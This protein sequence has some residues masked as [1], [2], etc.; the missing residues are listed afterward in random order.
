M[1]TLLINLRDKPT[2]KY[3]FLIDRRSIFGNPF[4]IGTD[5]DCKQV[6]EK[7]REYFY[8]RILTDEYFRDR[9]LELKGKVLAC[10]CSPLLCHGNIIIEYLN[11]I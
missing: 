9:V 5:G 3:D 1:T 2:P 6:V 10:W 8:K 7:Y 4:I 11:K